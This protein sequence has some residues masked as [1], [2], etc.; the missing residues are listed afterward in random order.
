MKTTKTCGECR[1][2]KNNRCMLPCYAMNH[3]ADNP[4]CHHFEEKTPPT[5]F[6]KITESV[7]TLAE[8]SVCKLDNGVYYSHLIGSFYSTKEKAIA[9]TVEGL[10]KEWKQI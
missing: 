7:E 6:D 8:V 1:Y 2:Y 10:K 9:A 3:W 4:A 5:V